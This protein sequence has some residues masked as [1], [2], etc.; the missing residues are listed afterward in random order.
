MQILKCLL[1]TFG[2]MTFMLVEQCQD[3]KP[4]KK[5]YFPS[6]RPAPQILSS[7]TRQQGL[8]CMD[9][10]AIQKRLLFGPASE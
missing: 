7:Q 5:H 3:E 8:T 6:T 9:C 2:I 4:E 10:F 1:S